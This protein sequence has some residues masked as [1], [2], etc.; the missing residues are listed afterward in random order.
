[1]RIENIKLNNQLKKR[2]KELRSKEE[3]GEG[4]HMIDF[5]QLKIENQTYNEKI[6]ERNEELMKLKKKINN[7][8]QVLS[9]VK[10]KLQFMNVENENEKEHLE[11]Y[12]DEVKKKR[13][14][15]NKIKQ[16][17]DSLRLDNAKLR[18]KGGLL[19]KNLLL[20]DFEDC[21]DKNDN[22]ESEIEQLKRRHAELTLTSRGIKQK[23]NQVKA[24][25]K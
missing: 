22:L 2:K 13:D 15:L 17:K 12:D 10:E 23:I 8:V 5:E 19:G 14:V 4:L 3:F 18:Q 6:E 11:F 21:I 9:H 1:V 25:Q 24:D 20:R 7:T 16:S